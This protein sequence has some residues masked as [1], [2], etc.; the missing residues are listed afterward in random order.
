MPIQ[1]IPHTDMP[2]PEDATSGVPTAVETQ[3]A[4]KP[5]PVLRHDHQNETIDTALELRQRAIRA[6]RED[7]TVLQA[8][9][10]LQLEAV[11]AN[12]ERLFIEIAEVA[13]RMSLAELDL[14]RTVIAAFVGPT[15]DAKRVLGYQLARL[16]SGAAR[17]DIPAERVAGAE[18][19]PRLAAIEPGAPKAQQTTVSRMAAY[20]LSDQEIRRAWLDVNTRAFPRFD[21]DLVTAVLFP[22]RLWPLLAAIVAEG[23]DAFHRRRHAFLRELRA[24]STREGKPGLTEGTV[25]TYLAT[26]QRLA[27]TLVALQARGYPDAGVA[28]WT[29]IPPKP[30]K[31]DYGV[32]RKTD[33]TAPS[34]VLVRSVMRP[35]WL[36]T[37]ERTR[38]ARRLGASGAGHTLLRD[39]LAVSLLCLTG[40]RR[41]TLSSMRISGFDPEHVFPEGDVGPAVHLLI[42]KTRTQNSIW[43]W[44][45]IPEA[46]TPYMLFMQEVF[47]HS[48]QEPDAPFWT[49]E[50]YPDP[51]SGHPVPATWT[52]AHLLQGNRSSYRSGLRNGRDAARKR[53]EAQGLLPEQVAEIVEAVTTREGTPLFRRPGGQPWEGYCAHTLRGYAFQLYCEAAD[54]YLRSDEGVQFAGRV[55]KYSIA[56]A[57]CDH[58]VVRDPYGYGQAQK[59]EYREQWSYR[60]ASIAWDLMVGDL[61]APMGID[62]DRVAAIEADIQSLEDHRDVQ[63]Q[64][65]VAVRAAL[66]SEM[67][68]LGDEDLVLPRG[69]AKMSES[70]LNAHL[71]MQRG[72]RRQ[73][74]RVLIDGADEKLEEATRV[75][76]ELDVELHDKREELKQ[77]RAALVPVPERVPADYVAPGGQRTYLPDEPTDGERRRSLVPRRQLIRIPELADILG[78]GPLQVSR[79]LQPDHPVHDSAQV[80]VPWTPDDLRAGRV[81]FELNKKNRWIRVEAI[82]Q[83]RWDPTMKARLIAL[84]ADELPF[85]VAVAYEQAEAGAAASGGAN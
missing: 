21:D 47:N 65:K 52:P 17:A 37:V 2:H 73:R 59:D 3:A 29:S 15:T 63:R 75:I 1:H 38:G 13:T 49:A 56:E 40:V 66:A 41:S 4:T 24:D 79:Y 77:A 5:K 23:P 51:D 70:E 14:V 22:P 6:K 33:R 81:L 67:D 57:I 50:I 39:F 16:V 78:I 61:G 42:V 62:V 43:R 76:A 71:T 68:R 58:N 12:R 72:E 45:A 32:P 31:G 26:Q 55:D 36:Y 82:D 46:L 11:P 34:P 19:E 27:G 9:R 74:T 7:E 69:F 18:V 8:Q 35:W 48:G 54:R 60:L 85:N 83:R 80:R 53:A 64:V 84:L 28:R 20:G 10:R 30:A 25:D 44:K